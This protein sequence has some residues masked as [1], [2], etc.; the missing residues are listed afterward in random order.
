MISQVI[1]FLT[2]KLARGRM[3]LTRNRVLSAS[4]VASLPVRASLALA[5]RSA[6]RCADLVCGWPGHTPDE[7]A[8]VDSL[9][10]GAERYSS[11]LQVVL[12]S[13]VYCDALK[14]V[15]AVGEYEKD[16]EIYPPYHAALSVAAAYHA[17]TASTASERINEVVYAVE[18]AAFAIRRFT[19][20]GLVFPA[21]TPMRAEFDLLLRT[22]RNESWMDETPVGPDLFAVDATLEQ[23]VALAINDLCVKLCSLIAEHPRALNLLDWRR[24]EEIVAT[25]LS[26][27][28]YRVELTPPSKDGGKDVIARCEIAGRLETYYVEIK[29]WISG[30]RVGMGEVSSFVEVN[31]RD[32]TQGGLFLSTTGYTNAVYAQLAEI[33]WRSLMLGND[34]TIISL[35][36]RF[37]WTKGQAMWQAVDV[38][39]LSDLRSI[40]H[41]ATVRY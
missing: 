38:L 1:N 26:G 11:G 40:R 2:R 9:V 13:P 6:R 31:V 5:A 4:E 41:T 20:G 3:D 30:K 33:S 39:P 21:V 7:R 10:T 16:C 35:C 19:D 25:A 22:A 27:L 24:L 32:G 14:T 36:Q 28:G 34:E 12:E 18:K 15:I 17:C 23:H 37:V 8:A 29:H